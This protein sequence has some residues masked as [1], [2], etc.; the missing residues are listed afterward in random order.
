M[1]CAYQSQEIGVAGDDDCRVELVRVGIGGE[2]VCEID[3]GLLFLVSFPSGVPVNKGATY[4]VDARLNG[5]GTDECIE[6][7]RV[8]FRPCVFGV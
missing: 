8:G 5:V 7:S 3:I 6:H 4:D 1:Q 2:L